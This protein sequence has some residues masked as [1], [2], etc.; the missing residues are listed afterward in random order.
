MF[1]KGESS[2]AVKKIL[3][4]GIVQSNHAMMINGMGTQNTNT[5]KDIISVSEVYEVL[6]A[7]LQLKLLQRS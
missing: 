5:K 2:H 3:P 1:V 6:N 7:T 4:S